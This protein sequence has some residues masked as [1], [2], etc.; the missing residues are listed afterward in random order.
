MMSTLVLSTSKRHM[1]GSLEHNHGECCGITVLTATCYWPL[2]SFHSCSEFVSLSAELNGSRSQWVLD[3]DKG[4]CSMLP[5][6]LLV[7]CELNKQTQPSRP[8]C[9]CWKLQDERF[10]FCWRLFRLVLLATPKGKR[11]EVEQ[12]PGGVTKSPKLCLVRLGAEPAELSA[13]VENRE[14]IWIL[15]GR[16]PRDSLEGK[17]GMKIITGKLTVQKHGQGSYAILNRTSLTFSKPFPDFLQT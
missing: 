8:G 4:V 12:G 2:K 3:S 7:V 5:P 1:N 17:A 6:L 14:V 13:I 10:A 16:L 9:H 15:L 11:S